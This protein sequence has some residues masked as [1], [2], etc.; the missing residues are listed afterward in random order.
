MRL[1]GKQGVTIVNKMTAVKKLV[2]TGMC[3]ALCVI[4]PMLFHGI[5]NAGSIFLPMHIPVLLCGL[6]CGAPYG[7]I[8]G[9]AGPFL[10]SM[11][12]GMPPMAYLPG[13]MI[14][15]AIYGLVSGL[16]MRTV[17]SGKLY[18]DLYLSLIVAM[19][20]GRIAGGA[21]NALIFAAGKYS[22]AAWTASYF[23]TCWPGLIIQLA[24]IPS[25]VVALEK[26]K[27]IDKRYQREE[28]RV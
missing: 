21:V 6:I 1:R 27:V 18:A 12:T 24:L 11:L 5:P 25:I 19:L 17:G 13:M 23:V 15:L 9:I 20:A 2:M 14:E 8:C 16:I 26:A 4:L 22:F 28:A 3:T 10:S 7:L